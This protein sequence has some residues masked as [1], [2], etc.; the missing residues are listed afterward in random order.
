MRF[1]ERKFKLGLQTE[2]E[3][4]CT[5]NPRRFWEQVERLGPGKV[6]KNIPLEVC[7]DDH[8]ITSHANVVLNT[9]QNDFSSLYSHG[10]DAAGN[11]DE[12]FYRNIELHKQN[13][14]NN[15]SDPQFDHNQLLNRDFTFA[16]VK[17]AVMKGKNRKAT[18]ID[19]IPYDVLKH[20]NIIDVLLHLFQMCFNS[21]KIPSVWRKSVILP[22]PKCRTNDSRMPLN[23]RGISLLSVV[24]KL[25]SSVLNQRLTTFLDNNSILVDEQNG[26]LKDRSCQ[27]HVFVLTSIIRNRLNNDLPTFVT[28]IDLQ[29]AFYF[30][31]RNVLLYKLLLNDIDG[32]MY[33][34]ISA[35]YSNASACVK[36]NDNYTDWFETVSGVRQGDNLSPTLFD[37]FINDLAKGIKDLNS[38]IQIGDDNVSVLLYADDIAVIAEDEENM[39]QMLDFITEWC[40]KMAAFDKQNEITY[41]SLQK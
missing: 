37:I 40:K 5:E 7:S 18:G 6:K 14:E 19:N 22:I 24:S 2:I 34:L 11:F 36:V 8:S 20:D 41:C 33:N 3:E 25:Y 23:Y 32:K 17:Y 13:L 16:E 35:L 9:W 4:I 29:K 31:D 26:F 15:F 28:F 27:D 38:G 12:E 10:R 1:Y 21:G 39:Q 30:V